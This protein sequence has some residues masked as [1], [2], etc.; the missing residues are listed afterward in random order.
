MHW[1]RK[2]GWAAALVAVVFAIGYGFLPRAVVVDTVAVSRGLLRDTVREEGKT[3]VAQRYVVSAPVA[4]YAQRVELEVGD[5]VKTGQLMVYL[6]PL[7]PEALNRRSQAQAEARV[8]AAEAAVQR[9]DDT[10]EASAADARQAEADLNRIQELF[11]AGIVAREQLDEAETE[12][13]RSKAELEAARAGV[14]V[15]RHELE[16]AKTALRYSAAEESSESRAST[17]KV[18]VRSPVSGR[19]LKVVHESEGVVAAGEAL[20]EI[21][22]PR[23]LEVEVEVLSSDAVKILQGMRVL[24]ERWGGEK[25]LE[26]I[27]RL[28]EPVG[29]TKISAL[30]VEEQ[31]VLII[32]DFV[33]PRERWERLGDQYR[34]EAVFILWEGDNVLQV[35]TSS[36]FRHGE[37]WAAFVLQDGKAQLRPVEIGHRSGL[38]AEILSGLEEGEAVIPHPDDSIEDGTLVERRAS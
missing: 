25:P 1:R 19:V 14:E 27:V 9:A 29:F 6:E 17:E 26:G 22:S 10:A 8:A 35:P 32:A 23:V 34:V 28:V 33:E 7:R 13:R 31:R 21:G 20:L 2:L 3:R 36:L 4:G 12:A 30:G 38:T 15:A 11:D 16:A 24:F 37:G 5:A 18:P